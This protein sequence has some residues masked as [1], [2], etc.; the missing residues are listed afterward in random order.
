LWALIFWFQLTNV[1][2]LQGELEHRSPKSRYTRTSHKDFVK[3][4]TQIERRQVRLRAI[5][6]RNQDAGIPLH[7]DVSATPEMHH[8]FG[9]SQ[10]LSENIPLFLQKHAGDPS[11]KA[12]IMFVC[13]MLMLI[14]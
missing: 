9:K 4:L 13:R 8:A 1:Y 2:N 12:W 5:R 14:M 10:K 11:I 7:E 3:Q 6:A